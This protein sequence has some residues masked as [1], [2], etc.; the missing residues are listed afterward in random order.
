MFSQKIQ[1]F[2]AFFQK[3]SFPPSKGG[4]VWGV[5]GVVVWVVVLFMAG[6]RLRYYID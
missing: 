6:K 3:S 4:G 1:K 5:E 2:W